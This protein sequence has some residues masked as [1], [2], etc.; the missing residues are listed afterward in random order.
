MKNSSFGSEVFLVV[1]LLVFMIIAL[2][3]SKFAPLHFGPV[4]GPT[5]VSVPQ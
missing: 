1:M 2:I 3:I 5:E 4:V